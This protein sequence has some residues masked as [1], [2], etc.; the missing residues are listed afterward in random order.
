MQMSEVRGQRSVTREE[1]IRAARSLLG[2]PFLHQGKLKETGFDCRGYLIAILHEF[3]I[4]PRHQHRDDY[5]RH[6]DPKEFRA[7]LE[8]E[9][10]LV[11]VADLKRADVVL[12]RELN[13]TDEEATHC[14]VIDEGPYGRLLLHT[15]WRHERCVEEP[16]RDAYQRLT[17][18]AFRFPGVID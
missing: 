16:Y 18:A 9:L 2:T 14:G 1:I 7:A 6:P 8:S 3:G 5:P 11:P 17:V 12:L 10:D 4:E 13:Q 15:T